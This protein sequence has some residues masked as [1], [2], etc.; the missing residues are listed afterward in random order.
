MTISG[1]TWAGQAMDDPAILTAMPEDLVVVLRATNGFIVRHGAL[2]V[3]GAC[4][5]PS[6]HS[7]R[8]ATEGDAA[9]SALYDEVLRTDI[10]FAEDMLGDQF[11]LRA[12]RVMRLVAE[13]GE[14]EEKE[15]SLKR[16]FERVEEDVAA[17]LNV[18]LDQR[19]DPGMLLSA[20]P[21]F[22]LDTE[23][24]YQLKSCP[25]EQVIAFHADF[26]RQIR[27]VGDGESVRIE[28]KQ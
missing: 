22:C 1:I 9:F 15:K 12:G 3:R 2:H 18:S 7:L 14:V 19:V 24:G 20:F 16:F 4:L 23:N 28:W 17:Y 25:S 26:A 10:P 8:H 11:L 27:S 6:W 13:T 5:T 21:P